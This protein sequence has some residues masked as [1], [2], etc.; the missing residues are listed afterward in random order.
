MKKALWTLI[1]QIP[2]VGG[3]AVL[4]KEVVK[5][6]LAALGLAVLYELFSFV[7]IFGS[8]VWKELEPQAVAGAAE[9][10]K[11]AFLNF[12]SRFR[13]RY[14]RQVIYDHRVFNVRGLR[15]TGTY[16]L[17]VEKVFV[18][19]RIAPGHL[20]QAGV[21]PTAFKEVSG[22]QPVWEFLRRMKAQQTIALAVIGPPG[23]GKT[24]LLQH[25]SLILAANKQNRYKLRPYSPLFLFLREHV[26]LIEKESPN[27]AELVQKH[28]SESKRYPGMKP[29]PRWFERNLARGKCLVL[30]DGLDE[31]AS[32]EHRETV[33][34]WID[35][36]VRAFPRCLFIITSRPGGYRE[37]PLARAHVLEIMPFNTQQ[38]A[39]F[40]HNWYLANKIISY[41]KDDPGVRQDAERQAQDLLFRLG[42]QSNLSA[43]TV[44][45][46]LLTMVAMVHN[47]RNTLPDRRVELYD[48]ICDVM[49]GHW[50]RAK[51]IAD[52]LTAAQERKALQP[53][54]A[55]MMNR[56]DERE[57]RTI[58]AK[59][60]LEVMETH[61]KKV[62]L[63]ESLVPHFLKDLQDCSGVFLEKEVDTWSFAHLTFQEYLCAKHWH[64]TGEAAAWTQIKWKSLIVDSWWHETLRLYAAQAN[65]TNLVNACLEMN[66][67][68]SLTL[69][70]DIGEEAL[71][72][73][74]SV[75]AAL[76]SRLEQDLESDDPGR[77]RLAAEVLLNRR[78]KKPFQS[79]DDT[80]SI[81]TGLITCA[82]Y[83]LFIDHMRSQKKYHQ[84][85]H[86]ATCHFPK[87]QALEPIAGVRFEDAEAFCLWLTQKQG[88]T[89]RLPRK[90]ETKS[91][92]K[93]CHT[94][95]GFWVKEG[96]VA[97]LS[98]GKEMRFLKELAQDKPLPLPCISV[99]SRGHAR[100][101][102]RARARAFDLDLDLALALIRLLALNFARLGTIPLDIVRNIARATL[103]DLARDLD[104]VRDRDCD[105]SL[106]PA[107]D[108]ARDLAHYYA[109]NI[110]VVLSSK[111]AKELQSKSVDESIYLIEKLLSINLSFHERQ[112]AKIISDT[113]YMAKAETLAEYRRASR[114]SS[115]NILE[116]AYKG[117]HVPEKRKRTRWKPWRRFQLSMDDTEKLKKYVLDVYWFLRMVQA[118]EA[119]KLPAWEGIRLV[120]EFES[121]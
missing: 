29:P 22:S 106:D 118:R 40:V 105:R 113:L 77:F 25:I 43:L 46:L 114:N 19:L 117:F 97:G 66:T 57:R 96:D 85:D 93:D 102:D 56:E 10:V 99:L 87:G 62:G 36:Q 67:I 49:L 91:C 116:Y 48:E 73:E 23:C 18:E 4:W 45:P 121:A 55:Y 30:L 107:R 34:R 12:F 98:P 7:I 20:Q 11:I 104:L 120:R 6:P 8:K 17:E 80:R 27:L 2:L 92:L 83:Q 119:G 41:G 50:R 37:A 75:R 47:Y 68:D 81:D 21:N 69:A 88:Q 70:A 35:E 26:Q 53:L 1:S 115:I 61:L 39:S 110:D 42:R 15:T 108:R 32:K 33:S 13:R 100:A 51:G 86:W 65:A 3:A 54:A 16:T 14:N 9:W 111:V 78:L 52:P 79:I 95:L 24:T 28:F 74:Q 84:P 31:V 59:E 90:E 58:S 82:E 64:E 71:E 94:F 63:E 103:F 38:T 44:N 76:N 5:H 72:L 112:W 89:F 60:A 101:L 109:Y